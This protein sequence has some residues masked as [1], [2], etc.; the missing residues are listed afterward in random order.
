MDEKVFESIANHVFVK[1]KAKYEKEINIDTSGITSDEDFFAYVS[2]RIEITRAFNERYTDELFKRV[3][4]FY[5]NKGL[6]R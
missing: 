2:K 6:G 1:L 3:I 4:N 5:E